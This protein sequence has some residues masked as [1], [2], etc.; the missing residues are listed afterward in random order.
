MP[1]TFSHPAIILPLT[2]LPRHWFS[3]TGLVIGSLTPDFEYFIRMRIKSEFSHTIEGLFWFDLPLGLILAFLFHSIVRDRL[4]DNLPTFLKSRFLSFQKFDWNEHFKKN[5]IVV[6]ISILIGGSSHIFW[7][8]FTH[9]HGYFVQTIPA[10]QNVVD[11]LGRQIPILKI[12]QHSSTL[13]GG[14]IIAFA[15]YKLPQ[16]KT[17]NDNINL[18]YWA[19]LVG[20]TSTIISIRLL[21]GLDLKQ[22]GNVIVTAISAGLI[23]LTITPWLTKSKKITGGNN[24]YT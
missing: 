9:D 20:L 2:F 23:S 21:S 19:I 15:I 17:E 16:S 8:S 10:L 18:K 1:F 6:S 24:G 5:W 3:L 11:F 12:L 7:D 13:L 4:F 14:L 22:Y